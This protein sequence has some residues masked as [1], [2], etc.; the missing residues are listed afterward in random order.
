MILI[1][2]DEIIPSDQDTL[3]THNYNFGGFLLVK[4]YRL[5]SFQELPD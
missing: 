5:I 1:G 2:S 4:N 3:E